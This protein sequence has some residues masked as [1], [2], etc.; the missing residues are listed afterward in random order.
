MVELGLVVLQEQKKRKGSPGGIHPITD[1]LRAWHMPDI[2][3]Y[4]PAFTRWQARNS[5]R[6]IQPPTGLL[7]ALS[8][9][10]QQISINHMVRTCGRRWNVFIRTDSNMMPY[11]PHVWWIC[12]R[13]S[14]Y[15]AAMNTLE[16][17]ST[18]YSTFFLVTDARK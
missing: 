1:C 13:D 2:L 11:L 17:P 14:T 4:I 3:L 6:Y 18:A 15:V 10:K 8:V 7:L 16:Y 12:Y 9:K 5:L